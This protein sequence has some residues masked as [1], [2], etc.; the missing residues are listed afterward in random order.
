[1]AGFTGE[2]LRDIH[3]PRFS[4]HARGLRSAWLKKQTPYSIQHP[5]PST[6]WELQSPANQHTQLA[7][8]CRVPSRRD[9]FWPSERGVSVRP[10]AS[11]VAQRREPPGQYYAGGMEA[12]R[13]AHWLRGG[14]SQWQADAR[15]ARNGGIGLR[16]R[17]WERE[18]GRHVMAVGR[19]WK[20]NSGQIFGR[21]TGVSEPLTR[22]TE[23]H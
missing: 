7:C 6:S 18:V 3:Y 15:W 10:R 16:E 5:L 23:S 9:I 21:S 8:S 13:G 20:G 4:R 2:F 19:G 17:E 11:V 14:M 1:M 22:S 12:G